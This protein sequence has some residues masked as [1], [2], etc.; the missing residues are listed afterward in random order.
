MDGNRHSIILHI[1]HGKTGSSYIQS[2]LALS[3]GRLRNVGIEYPELETFEWAIRGGIS[4]GNMGAAENFVQTV[5]DVSRRHAQANR[6]LFSGEFLFHR[7]A[8]DRE[9]LATLQKSF[10]VTV[11]L[12]TRE[13]LAHALSAYGQ[14][15][16]RGGGTTTFANY[17]P[18][19]RR[20]QEVL[21]VLE[22]V[23]RSGCRVRIHNYSRHAN[24]L[25]DV[26]AEAIGV[27]IETLMRPPVPRVNRSLDEAELS[28]VRSLNAVTD[29]Q[30]SERLADAL[31]E[32]LPDH[33]PE[34]PRISRRDYEAFRAWVA[35][36]EERINRFLPP[37]ERYGADEPIRVEDN[38]EPRGVVTFSEAQ[39]RVVAESLGGEI[40][41]L[42]T[43]RFEP[44]QPEGRIACLLR[45]V[46][47]GLSELS[48]D[49][50]ERH[51]R[52]IVAGSPLFDAEW[53]AG[54][55]PEVKEAGLDPLTHFLESGA[56]DRRLPSV[57]FDTAA[58]LDRYPDVRTSGLNPLYHYLQYGKRESRQISPRAR[59]NVS[60]PIPSAR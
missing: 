59:P 1:G 45:R 15:V 16:K 11:V 30:T 18:E 52:R 3:A 47:V 28:L 49:I 50:S 51:V 48:K 7:I 54:F 58:Y 20:P 25:L 36:I 46:A 57:H 39:M 53:Y 31:C 23:E 21:K 43:P 13:F 26:F 27:P 41:R 34:T 17:L 9:S 44:R 24:R 14:Y 22:A 33:L 4:S 35:P 10:D 42:S 8:A 32:R 60:N 6:L 12:F 37:S 29:R 2:S 55:Y 56:Q 38:D 5:I 40:N 19:Y